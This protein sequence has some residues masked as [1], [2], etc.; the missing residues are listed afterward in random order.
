MAQRF[1]IQG[2]ITPLAQLMGDASPLQTLGIPLPEQQLAA[3]KL[4]PAPALPEPAGMA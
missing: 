1:P 2:G 3:A 4:A